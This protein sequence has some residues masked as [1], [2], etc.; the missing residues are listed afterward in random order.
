MMSRS[1]EKIKQLEQVDKLIRALKDTILFKDSDIELLF[2]YIKN[3]TEAYDKLAV[4]FEIAT[5]ILSDFV[6]DYDL[7][8]D[9]FPTGKWQTV[10]KLLEYLDARQ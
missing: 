7:D 10:E 2:N 6:G 1:N 5:G 4:E 3:I 9:Y 8:F